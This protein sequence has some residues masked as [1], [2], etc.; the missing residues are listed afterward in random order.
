MIQFLHGSMNISFQCRFYYLLHRNAV[1]ESG[2]S[3]P[4]KFASGYFK[5][6]LA[7]LVHILNLAVCIQHNEPF[8]HIF[9][10]CS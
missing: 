9:R 6:I 5:Q 4:D 8:I 10:N 7:A 2:N 3:L 1:T